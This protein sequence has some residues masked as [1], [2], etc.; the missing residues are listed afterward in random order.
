[1][2]FELQ[3]SH[4][5]RIELHATE[6]YPHECI[7]ILLGKE[8]HGLKTVLEVVPLQNRWEHSEINPYES[9]PQDST[10]N[11]SLIDPKDFL[12][13]DQ[14]AR[15]QGMDIVGFYHSHPDH[16]ARPSEF[17]RI[18]AWP[19][20]TYVILAVEKGTP[21]ELTAWLLSEDQTR[22][23]PEALSIK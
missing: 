10:R 22:L 6:C 1:M 17:D 5:A 12:H 3:Q 9:R 11:R 4:K 20:Y 19:W 8:A 13:A 15:S 2:P 21:R 16:P 7:G 18:N 23:L 14:R